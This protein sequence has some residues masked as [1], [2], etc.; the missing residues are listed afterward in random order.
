MR[1]LILHR[2]FPALLVLTL[3]MPLARSQNYVPSGEDVKAFL[4][5]R[6]MVVLEDNPLSMYNTWIREAVE[7]NWKI[8]GYD[9]IPYSEFDKYKNDPAYS[10]LMT[11][12]VF[13]ERDK[14][15]ARYKF[16]NLLLGGDARRL[17]DMP[18]L[19]PVPL[20]YLNADEDNYLYK[21]DVFVRFMQNHIE[22]LLKNPKIYSSNVF[23]YYNDNLSTGVRNK[24]L[25]VL[26]HELASEVNTREKIA[27]YYPYKVEIVSGEQ[28]D[29]AIRTKDHNVVFLHKVG[30]EGT[31]MNARCYKVLIGAGD[32]NFYFFDHHMIKVPK[33]PDGI[34]SGD[35]KRLARK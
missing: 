4:K 26:R 19:C 11:T 9:F 22:I 18:D 14:L 31:R 10:F 13:F 15:K 27:K 20:A 32:A 33:K 2:I 34:L 3:T 1:R 21:L 30:P 6:T 8:T 7:R 5:T 17:S 25:Y 12:D 28:M 29:E 23:K 35:F 24:T 16:L